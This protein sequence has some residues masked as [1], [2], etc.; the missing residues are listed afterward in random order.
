MNTLIEK[1]GVPANDPLD[2]EPAY[3]LLNNRAIAEMN[4]SGLV[5]FGA[6]TC[7]HAILSRLSSKQQR[8]EIE[9]ALTAVRKLTGRPCR[10]FAYPNGLSGD[11]DDRTLE[12]L[13]ENRVR[14]A[15]TATPGINVPKTPLLELRRFSVG[16]KTTIGRLI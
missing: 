5:E 9:D 6:H 12:I 14:A 2:V 13:R 15:L 11:Y 8:Q 1:L 3:R 10:Y 4:E 7:S 16:P